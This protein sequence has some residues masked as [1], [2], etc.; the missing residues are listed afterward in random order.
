MMTG[1]KFSH[2]IHYDASPDEVFAM[3]SDPSFRQRS[4][5]AMDAKA[6]EIK[7]EARGEGMSLRI[8]QEQV[9]A[10]VP[11]FAKKF[12]GETTRVIHSEEWPSSS[13]GTLTIETPGKPTSLTGT[14][15]L[16]PSGSGTAE[17]F[18]GEIKVKVPLIGG[19]LESLMA[20]LFTQGM[21]KEHAVGVAWLAGDR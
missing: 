3:L 16:K 15:T 1:M 8:D 10:G 14:L 11:S 19:K 20:D 12:A 2:E 13:S 18:D 6:T 4:L 21:D 9:T 7:V 17:V 5:D